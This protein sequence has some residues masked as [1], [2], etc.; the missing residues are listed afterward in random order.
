MMNSITS[1]KVESH[2][3]PSTS[4]FPSTTP[5]STSKPTG[6]VSPIVKSELTRSKDEGDEE[7]CLIVWDFKVFE[8]VI[9]FLKEKDQRM[10]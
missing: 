1:P 9:K 4:A 3:K 7:V 6:K 2:D 8:E 5:A 10:I